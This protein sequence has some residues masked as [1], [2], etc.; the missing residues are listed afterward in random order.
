MFY[1]DGVGASLTET[2]YQ[3][4]GILADLT[5][6]ATHGNAFL[7]RMGGSHNSGQNDSIISVKMDTHDIYKYAVKTVPVVVKKTWIR[8]SSCGSS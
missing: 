4:T 2:T 3:D 8:P 6:P 1:F 5:C 7:L